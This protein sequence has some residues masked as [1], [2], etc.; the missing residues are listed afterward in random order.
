MPVINGKYHM[1]PQYRSAL[2]RD[3]IRDLEFARLHGEP[4]PSWLDHFLGFADKAITSQT[5]AAGRNANDARRSASTQAADRAIA[6][7][8]YNETSGLRSTS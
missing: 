4:E 1:N 8:V 3:R 2:E 6:A 7:L 5:A